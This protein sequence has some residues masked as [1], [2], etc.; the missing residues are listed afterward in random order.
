MLAI[1]PNAQTASSTQV[2]ANGTNF[3]NQRNVVL[4]A[5]YDYERTGAPLK[6]ARLHFNRFCEDQVA[7]YLKKDPSIE[8]NENWRFTSFDVAAGKVRVNSFD[9][10]TEKRNW[11]DLQGSSQVPVTED[12]YSN[13]T[14]VY[15]V[16]DTVPQNASPSD[17]ISITDVYKFVCDLGVNQPGSLLE[18]SFF[19]HGWSGGPI[20]VNYYEPDKKRTDRAPYDKDARQLADFRPP[21]MDDVARTNFGNAFHANGFIWVWGCNFADLFHDTINKI[22]TSVAYNTSQGPADS[23]VFV[24]QYT[25]AQANEYFDGVPWFFP[26]YDATKTQFSVTKTFQELKQLFRAG[27]AST[28]CHAIASVAGRTC[29]GTLPGMYAT[30]GVQPLGLMLVPRDAANYGIDFSSY[31]RFY[32]KYLGAVIDSDGRGYAKYLP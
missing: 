8:E 23:D 11:T 32:T 10:N 30:Y 31:V 28:Y 19:S 26:P 14:T 13:K 25:Q 16:F 22:V 15:P 17:V 6:I 24:L 18:L 2:N 5:G 1:D 20:L 21:T 29:Y 7:R 27:L 4:V 9:T 12:N 3:T